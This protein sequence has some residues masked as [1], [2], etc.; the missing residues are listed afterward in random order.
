MLAPW[1]SGILIT[2]MKAE[3]GYTVIFTI[4]LI[5]FVIGAVVSFFL[6]KREV[7]GTYDWRHSIVQ[8]GDSQSPWREVC[9]ALI[10]QGIRE[11]VFGF[12]IGLLVYISTK[13][14]WNLGNYALIT[15]AVGFISFFA[16]GRFLKP[17]YRRKGALWGAV[18][19][20]AVIFLFFWRV[21][22]KTLLMFGIATAIFF[23]L[24]TI[25]MTSS[26]F[27]IIGQ[28]QESAERRVEYVVLR[29]LS[30]ITGRMS[31]ILIFIVVVL[32]STMPLIIN[33]MLLGIGSSPIFAW[34]FMRKHYSSRFR[35]S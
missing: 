3:K 8:L 4:S 34:V 7:S 15:S 13:S 22:Y 28:D 20:V 21:D 23:P 30:L 32:N 9:P 27:D 18:I 12:A 5:I 19:M 29:E 10:F 16:V 35:P 25:P 2:E 11:G 14:E 1:M 26:V 33:F 6:K 24:Y 31:G 17:K